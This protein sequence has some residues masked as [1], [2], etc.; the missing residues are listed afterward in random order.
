MGA[1]KYVVLALVVLLASVS[2]AF[3]LDHKALGV[4]LEKARSQ[5]T[6]LTAALV[7]EQQSRA[8]FQKTAESCSGS[9]A[10][11]VD[12]G[13]K[14]EQWYSARLAAS[15]KEK[16]AAEQAAREILTSQRPAGMSECD[17]TNK[18]LNDEI[19]RRHPAAAH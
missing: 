9:V 16:A 10:R 4:E 18:E 17:A 14:R 2:V 8:A 3:Y 19:D 6:D 1:L 13:K 5:V 15:Q 7:R 12:E 11:L